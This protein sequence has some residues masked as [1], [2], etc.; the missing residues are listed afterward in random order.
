MITNKLSDMEYIL[1]NLLYVGLVD[2]SELL[3]NIEAQI[4][5]VKAEALSRK[6]ITDRIQRWLSACEEENW[7]ED[8]NLVMFFSYIILVNNLRFVYSRA[9]LLVKMSFRLSHISIL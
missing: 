8:Y 6:E 7:L 5:K 1:L 3:V 9:P 4:S 2:P